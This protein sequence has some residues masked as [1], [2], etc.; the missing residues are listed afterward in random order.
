MGEPPPAVMEAS[1]AGVPVVSADRPPRAALQPAPTSTM[2]QPGMFSTFVRGG[3]RRPGR[4]PDLGASSAPRPPPPC[5]PR[6]PRWPEAGRRAGPGAAQHRPAGPPLPRLDEDHDTLRTGPGNWPAELRG[7]RPTAPP[8]SR[9]T[10]GRVSRTVPARRTVDRRRPDRTAPRTR[11]RP[12][13]LPIPWSSRATAPGGRRSTPAREHGIPLLA[14]PSS[15]LARG[16]GRV[17]TRASWTPPSG[18]RSTPAVLA[19]GPP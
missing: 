3:G 5:S 12:Q 10:R 4:D 17:L 1:H 11:A 2:R 16:G 15:T 9:P 19:H 6:S 14:E 8:I 7:T 13:H 18:G